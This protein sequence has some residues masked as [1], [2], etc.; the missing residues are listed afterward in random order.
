MVMKKVEKEL[1]E[2]FI[3][4]MINDN[5][6]LE[7]GVYAIWKKQ[8]ED[9]KFQKQTIDDNGV[10]FGALDAGILT[11]FGNQLDKRFKD[12]NNTNTW[13]SYLSEK[14]HVIARRLMPKYAGQLVYISLGE[15]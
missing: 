8:T 12:R 11:S 14:Q 15:K 4:N 7:R 1:K 3:Y 5:R 10:G 9:E 2:K 6:W 13:G